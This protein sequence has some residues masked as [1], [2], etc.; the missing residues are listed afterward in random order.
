MRSSR[1]LRRTTFTYPTSLDTQTW[2]RIAFEGSGQLGVCMIPFATALIRA[3]IPLPHAG[4]RHGAVT[5]LLIVCLTKLGFAKILIDT[6]K[7]CK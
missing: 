1:C 5:T 6:V 4:T 2:L 7:P 3:N